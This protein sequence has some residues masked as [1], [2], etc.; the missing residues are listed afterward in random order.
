MSNSKEQSKCNPAEAGDLL[1]K[2]HIQFFKR[3]MN[4]IPPSAIAMDTN[5][6]ALMA[7]EYVIV[8]MEWM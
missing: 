3:V 8:A 5:R 7:T 4:V 2:K 1:I 6:S